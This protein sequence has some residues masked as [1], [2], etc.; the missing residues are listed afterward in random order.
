[1]QAILMPEPGRAVVT[2]VPDPLPRPGEALLRVRRV[3]LCGSD[4][5]SFRGLN[6]LVSYPRIPGHEIAATVLSLPETLPAELRALAV[7]MDV[8][9]SPYSSCGHCSACLAQ[10]PNACQHNQT[11][12]VQRDGALA[13]RIAVPVDR[14]FPATLGDPPLTLEELVLVEPLTVGFHAVARAR[15]QPSETVLILGS[16]GVGLG[17]VAAAATRGATVLA[18][19]L[20]EARLTTARLAGAAHTLRFDPATLADSVRALTDGHGPSVVI[21]AVGT[22]ETFCT[23]VDLVAFAGRVVYIGYAKQPVAYETRLFVQKELDIRG[24]RNALPEDFRAVIQMLSARRF[25]VH[26]AIGSIVPFAK[27]PETFIRWKDDPGAFT[28]IVIALD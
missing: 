6:P 7:G 11:L 21:E 2:T 3:G 17:A 27:A 20:S 10:R 4:L 13:E 22:P 26:A 14:L 12:G 15:V 28:K 1:M 25:P 8:T 19:D 18:V 24:S 23:A 5:N 16:G 9:L